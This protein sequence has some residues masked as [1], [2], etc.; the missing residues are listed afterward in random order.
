M[1]YGVPCAVLLPAGQSVDEPSTPSSPTAARGRS[2]TRRA[3][4]EVSRH[5]EVPRRAAEAG[6]CTSCALRP[7]P[8]PCLG[9]DEVGDE[10]VCQSQCLSLIHISEPTRR[11]PI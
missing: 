7:E 5:A 9:S 8:S 1:T 6:R 3:A 11:T 10:L 4:E 2:P